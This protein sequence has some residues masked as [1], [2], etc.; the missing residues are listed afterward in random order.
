[1]ARLRKNIELD[2]QWRSVHNAS[3]DIIEDVLPFVASVTIY[4]VLIALASYF[5]TNLRHSPIVHIIGYP[6][7]FLA[8]I[9]GWIIGALTIGLVGGNIHFA[10]S[11]FPMLKDSIFVYT[12]AVLFFGF[13]IAGLVAGILRRIVIT[14]K[15]K[16][17]MFFSLL[18]ILLFA[19][20]RACEVLASS[21]QAKDY[22][23]YVFVYALLCI[24]YILVALRR[25]RNNEG[26]EVFVPGGHASFED[27][28]DF[29][30]IFV[31][32]GSQE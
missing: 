13:F 21:H 6:L 32:S 17:Y 22:Q 3:Q 31:N 28:G 29:K 10:N 30:D 25:H 2:G 20:Y 9:A 16:R 27:I 15:A 26:E 23:K 19:G 8:V 12:N 24:P 1:M 18:F 7:S 5:S 14:Y 11:L 4:A